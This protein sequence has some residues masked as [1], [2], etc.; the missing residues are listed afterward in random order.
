VSSSLFSLLCP[1]VPFH[2]AS[3]PSPPSS[4]SSCPILPPFLPPSPH[5]RSAMTLASMYKTDYVQSLDQHSQT[6]LNSSWVNDKGT[7]PH[8]ASLSPPFSSF[9]SPPSDTSAATVHRLYLYR[10]LEDKN[11]ALALDALPQEVHPSSCLR[12]LLV[13]LVQ[14]RQH[15]TFVRQKGT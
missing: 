3:A 15:S 14:P 13:S 11:R 2:P 1:P 9:S 5:H 10:L 7:Q 4:S 6:N 12:S 8:P